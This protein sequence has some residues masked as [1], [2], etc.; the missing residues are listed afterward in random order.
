MDGEVLIVAAVA[1]VGALVVAPI[2]TLVKVVKIGRRQ[3]RLADA[4]EALE[5]TLKREIARLAPALKPAST[6]EP[7]AVV[8]SKPIQSAPALHVVPPVPERP[9]PLSAAAA[10]P[11][12]IPLR[13]TAPVPW[14]VEKPAPAAPVARQPG[15]LEEAAVRIIRQVWNW[16]VVGEEHRPSGVSM[17]YAIATNWLLR[18]GVVILV[19]GMGFFLRYS[20]EKGLIGPWG[21]VSISTLVAVAMLG[22]GM[23][24]LGRRYHL[25]GQGLL[26]AGLATLYFSAF[27]AFSFYHLVEQVPAFG[28]MIL[29][30][31]AAGAMAVCFNSLL[32]AVL[33][34]VGGYGTPVM[35]STGA[36]QFVGLFA[37]MLL[38]GI[39]ALGVAYR[40]NWRLLTVL[41]FAA[42]YA[43]F[44]AALSRHYTTTEF[45]HVMPFLAAFFVLFSTMVFIHN[46]ARGVPATMI[47]IVML[48]ANAAIV[49]GAGH[50]LITHAFPRKWASVMTLALAAFY[51]VHVSVCLARRLRDRPLITTFIGLAS[52][53]LVV[54]VPLLLSREWITVSWS[55]QALI[56]L[57]MAGSLR[58][59]FL[60]QV[61]Y[62]LY[63]LVL[64]RLLVLDLPHQF[65]D[66]AVAGKVARSLGEYGRSLVERLAMFGI[67]IGSLAAAQRLLRRGGQATGRAALDAANDV[68]GWVAQ[69]WAARL[70]VVACGAT[71][72][73]YLHLELNRSLLFMYPP[74][75]LPVLTWLWAAAALLVLSACR[76]DAALWLR[77]LFAA[78][79]TGAVVKTVMIDAGS[80]GFDGGLL[81]YAGP[82]SALDAGMRLLDAAAVIGLLVYGFATL[83]AATARTDDR[84][85][86]VGMGYVALALLFV[87]T[88]LEMNTFLFAF[89]PGLRAGGVSLLWS[90]FALAFVFAGVLRGVLCLRYAGLALFSVTAVKVFVSDL[91]HLEQIYR[92]V[93]FIALGLVLLV[94]AFVYLKFRARF[95]VKSEAAE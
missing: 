48:L 49:F 55:C 25:L 9:K 33:G 7:P 77:G 57:W 32:I 12:A 81:R 62:L 54:T 31:V 36:V 24:L 60:R 5:K 72:F 69:R 66:H 23:R 21:R 74:V 42:T 93:A 86:G 19:V 68:R 89:V 35:L 34:L 71:L 41:S 56:L 53:F 46:V 73:L 65:A 18:V 58:S 47:E 70:I 52:F 95:A 51:A 6:P 76:S 40:R 94:A 27:A 1:L 91:A 3:T 15:K 17:E 26:G 78:L 8:T 38:L 14:T 84:G 90:A 85:A 87:Y 29:I 16:I 10:A 61:A 59:E 79:V 13:S 43:L 80:W 92:I 75:R 20:Y 64:G 4:V 50:Y 63:A 67:P 44:F 22:T 88:S 2:A 30:T 37:Y 45:W 39:G 28:M 82:Y 83:R 11:P